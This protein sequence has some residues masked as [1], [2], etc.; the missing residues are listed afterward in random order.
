MNYCKIRRLHLYKNSLFL[1]HY[2]DCENVADLY[3]LLDGSGSINQ[4]NFNI[5]KQFASDLVGD[6][7]VSPSYPQIQT[8]NLSE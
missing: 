3:M 5:M 8:R 1:Y 6:L 2:A 7:S 4:G